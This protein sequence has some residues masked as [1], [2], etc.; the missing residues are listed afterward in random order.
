MLIEKHCTDTKEHFCKVCNWVKRARSWETDAVTALRSGAIL[1]KAPVPQS[2]HL[3]QTEMIT[4]SRPTPC[5]GCED[6]M[7]KHTRKSFES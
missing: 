7:K 3:S 5:C 1:D 2:P 4:P 6:Q